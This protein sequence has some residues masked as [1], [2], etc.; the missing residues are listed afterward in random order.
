MLGSRTLSNV[1][2]WIPVLVAM[3]AVMRHDGIYGLITSTSNLIECGAASILRS[4][5]A[6]GTGA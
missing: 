6:A 5:S 2:I 4:R 3:L 1:T